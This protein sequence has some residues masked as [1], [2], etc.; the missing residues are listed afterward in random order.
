MLQGIVLTPWIIIFFTE[1]SSGG[2]GD[3]TSDWTY[4]SEYSSSN[5][6]SLFQTSNRL[7]TGLLLIDDQLIPRHKGRRCLE[8]LLEK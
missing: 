1:E 3:Y 7:K 6:L 2:G 5:S 4:D 8:L